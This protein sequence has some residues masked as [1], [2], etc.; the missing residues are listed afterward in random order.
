MIKQQKII[1]NGVVI[2]ILLFFLIGGFEFVISGLGQSQVERF[3]NDEIPLLCSNAEKHP[4]G[5]M[6]V[7]TSC[8]DD[9]IDG[10]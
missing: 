1:K 3:G 2:I 4:L 9:D 10:R 5:T 7:K 8:C 6:T